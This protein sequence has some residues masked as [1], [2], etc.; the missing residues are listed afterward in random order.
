MSRL[1]QII[2]I[3]LLSLGVFNAASLEVEGNALV[4]TIRTGPLLKTVQERRVRF[5]CDG[6]EITPTIKIIDSEEFISLEIPIKEAIFSKKGEI[7]I[8]P[9]DA[10]YWFFDYGYGEASRE[11]AGKMLG[12]ECPFY[13]DVVKL[14]D[15]KFSF[16]RE[17]GVVCIDILIPNSNK[18]FRK[19]GYYAFG[20]KLESRKMK[21]GKFSYMAEC[22][23]STL[24]ATD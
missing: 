12:S 8:K 21:N 6:K 1:L 24:Y 17:T 10:K 15:L 18:Q 3:T 20:R 7:Y 5:E 4:G 19:L 14:W 13:E 2:F 22:Y 11:K 16:D 23:L 9:A